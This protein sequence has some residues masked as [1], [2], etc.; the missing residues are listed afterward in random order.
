MTKPSPIALVVCD[1]L[2]QDPS[3]KAA[4][5]GLF[6]KLVAAK[7][8]ATHPQMCVYASVTEVR[9]GTKFRL[10]IEHAENGKRIAELLAE[11][12]PEAIS[13]PTT[14]LDLR[15]ILQALTFPEPGRYFIQFWANDNLLLQR[16]FDAV[17]MQ[18]TGGSGQ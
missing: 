13:N 2:Y 15:F 14:I 12:P 5:V 9:T 3:G 6:N 18:H 16:P 8:P 4:L 11:P 7:F 1:A 10:V 17:L